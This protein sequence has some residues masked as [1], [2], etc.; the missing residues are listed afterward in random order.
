MVLAGFE[1]TLTLR[2]LPIVPQ[3]SCSLSRGTRLAINFSLK[4]LDMY[5]KKKAYGAA[6]NALFFVSDLI[7][8]KVLVMTATNRLISQKLRTIMATIKKKHEIKNSAS[9]IWYMSPDHYDSKVSF[10]LRAKSL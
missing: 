2:L 7:A 5:N 4:L 9:I 1:R 8:A 6:P 10:D 3:S